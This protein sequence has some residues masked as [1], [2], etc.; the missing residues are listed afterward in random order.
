MLKNMRWER[1]GHVARMDKGRAVKKLFENK[2]EES[3]KREDLD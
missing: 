1:T 2:P 3:I